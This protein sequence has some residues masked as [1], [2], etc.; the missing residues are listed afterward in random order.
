MCLLLHS[1]HKNIVKLQ[2]H[3]LTKK[4]RKNQL[5]AECVC[6]LKMNWNA[7]PWS[8]VDLNKASALTKKYEQI[9]CGIVYH[10]PSL[11]DDMKNYLFHSRRS[12]EFEYLNY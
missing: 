3:A 1:R 12:I 8:S 7:R 11:N 5:M 10:P 2:G 6:M 4:D 9:I